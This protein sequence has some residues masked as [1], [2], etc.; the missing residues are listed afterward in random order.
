MR[1]SGEER[2]EPSGWEGNALT[3]V[4]VATFRDGMSLGRG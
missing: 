1:K 4:N 2:A 3:P